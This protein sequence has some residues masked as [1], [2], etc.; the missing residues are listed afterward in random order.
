MPTPNPLLD[1]NQPPNPLDNPLLPPTSLGAHVA[2]GT[3]QSAGA[4]PSPSTAPLT[5]G[6]A[7]PPVNPLL[8]TPAP[9][10]QPPALNAPS[11][12]APAANPPGRT[13]P[14]LTDDARRARNNQAGNALG[15]R[16]W[17]EVSEGEPDYDQAVLKQELDGNEFDP[18][19]GANGLFYSYD[20]KSMRFKNA[21]GKIVNGSPDQTAAA[22]QD[23]ATWSGAGSKW[24]PNGVGGGAGGPGGGGAAGPSSDLNAYIKRLLSGEADPY[25]ESAIDR[26]ES[27]AFDETAGGVEAAKRDAQLRTRRG[28]GLY[29]SASGS[30]ALDIEKAGRSDVSRAYNDVETKAVDANHASKLEGLKAGLAQQQQE[31]DERMA[32]A[33][34]AVERESI[35]SQYKGL[36]DSTNAKI[37][38][39][40][41]LGQKQMDSERGS[42]AAARAFAREQEQTAWERE[43][44]RRGYEENFRT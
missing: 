41:A 26:L 42:G 23:Q 7:T 40:A 38:A 28:G 10:K 37:K 20:G 13:T 5:P 32:N 1:P 36:M 8:P 4:A 15:G 24:D 22:F 14:L 27:S 3:V 17:R 18:V 9:V 43:L 33:K 25:N 21:D 12:G 30:A 34:N 31:L 35:A 11:T 29:S 19:P 39:E 16:S 44:N 2:A 6:P